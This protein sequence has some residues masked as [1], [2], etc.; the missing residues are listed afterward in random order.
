MIYETIMRLC[1]S[2]DN[3]GKIAFIISHRLSTATSSDHIYMLENGE[4]VENGT[5]KELFSSGGAYA[6]MY[7]MQ[8]KNY[9]LEEARNEP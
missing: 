7:S 5:H 4:V 1:S 8:A 2:E 3:E 9:L 6:R